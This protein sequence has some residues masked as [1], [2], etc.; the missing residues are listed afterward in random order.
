MKNFK[1]IMDYEGYLINDQGVVL[2]INHPRR[3]K[4]YAK[5]MKAVTLSNGYQSVTL[6]DKT[7]DPVRKAFLIQRLVMEAFGP[8][9]PSEDHRIHFSDFDRTNHSI[10]NLIWVTHSDLTK[11]TWERN[12]DKGVRMGRQGRPIVLTIDNIPV[13]KYDSIKTAYHKTRNSQIAKHCDYNKLDKDD[14]HS[15]WWASEYEDK[16]G[17]ID[18]HEP[19]YFTKDDV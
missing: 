5:Q 18:Y 15:W 11:L 6:Y 14:I 4:G 2:S 17:S 1:Q 9:K 3:P 10:Y 7:K 16:Y 19:T 13:I 8:E 12:R